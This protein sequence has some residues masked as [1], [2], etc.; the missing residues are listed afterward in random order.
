MK[1]NKNHD[2][3]RDVWGSELLRITVVVMVFICYR[4][5]Q[6]AAVGWAGTKPHRI[7]NECFCLLRTGKPSLSMS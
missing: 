7:I 4:V 3:N 1:I 5:L 2:N 6:F